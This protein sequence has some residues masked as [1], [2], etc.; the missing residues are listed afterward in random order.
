MGR[1]PGEAGDDRV[2][3]PV[4]EP[5]RAE[6]AVQ[7]A[8]DASHAVEATESYQ[9]D[10]GA[11]IYGT[12]VFNE[13]VQRQY[14]PKPI[15]RRLRRVIDGL[16]PFSPDIADAVDHHDQRFGIGLDASEKAALVAF[17]SAL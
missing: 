3:G 14:L 17:L 5:G 13:S 8:G 15:F 10:G 1:E 6:G 12:Y 7:R 16:E 9:E 11:D 4:A 2:G